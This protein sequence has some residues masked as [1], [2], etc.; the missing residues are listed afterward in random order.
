MPNAQQPGSEPSASSPGNAPR[1][2]LDEISEDFAANAAPGGKVYNDQA[3]IIQW[4]GGELPRAVDD[5]ESA[6]LASHV[7]L[8][9]R[10]PFIVRAA[11]RPPMSS[12]D[13]ERP[14]GSLGIVSVDR[15]YLT[16][17][18]TRVAH[19]ERHDKRDDKWKPINCPGDV[20]ATYLARRGLWRLP[21]LLSVVSAPT[22]R[23]DGTVLQ[24]PGYDS[25]TATLYE[26]CG[27]TFADIPND[28]SRSDAMDALAFLRRTFNTFPF[29]NERGGAD[30]S[31]DEAVFIAAVLQA[32][33]R[34][35]LDTAPLI[36]FS[37]TVM[38][39][40]KSLLATSVGLIA[41]GIGPTIMR[42][43]ETN[44]EAAKLALSVLLQ[45]ESVVVLDNVDRAIEGD[46]L[47]I[48]LSEEKYS[49]RML[50]S[51]EVIEVPTNVTWLAT[52]NNAV[53]AGD[54]R[55]RALLCRID[56][57]CE[58]PSSRRFEVDLRDWIPQHRAELVAAALTIMRA[59]VVSGERVEE[60]CTP[61]DRFKRWSNM[62]RTPLIWLGMADPCDSLRL[63]E[64][65]DPKRATLLRL[66]NHWHS[67][68]GGNYPNGNP[69]PQKKKAS[70][71][72]TEFLDSAAANP[73]AVDPDY[74]ELIY[75]IAGDR[76]GT[77]RS[78]KLAAYLR[79][80]VGRIIDGKKIEKGEEENG[81]TLWS[82]VDVTGRRGTSGT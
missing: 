57:D 10:G 11:P 40:G 35:S 53:L 33:V 17:L 55:T 1:S 44:E 24:R 3:P 48:I 70:E 62:V 61:W 9:Q 5:A 38:E 4:V 65:E 19:W 13:F 59:F 77:L 73:G 47:C 42:Y 66:L 29:V 82:V 45:G 80:H 50:G 30:T 6:L 26:P 58:H 81:T 60:F 69:G 16:E 18:L 51:L 68:Y 41:N 2:P 32:V 34:K 76:G 21:P 63:L 28:P 8:F 64:K 74:R 15:A 75:Q 52:A 56:P 67:R 72:I 39:S 36:T 37:A 7:R 20:A 27:M 46:W 22:L 78:M 23:P 71:V 43:P 25:S 79:A 12:R 49:G 14:A 54:V 31:V